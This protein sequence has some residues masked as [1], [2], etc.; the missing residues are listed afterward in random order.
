VTKLLTPDEIRRFD[1][2]S[3]KIQKPAENIENNPVL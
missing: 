3:S 1:G 2:K